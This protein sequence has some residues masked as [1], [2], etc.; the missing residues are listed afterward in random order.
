M[1]T[2]ATGSP[3]DA[4]N[5][6]PRQ[7]APRD[8]APAH[9]GF[10]GAAV[11]RIS[12]DCGAFCLRGW[13]EQGLTPARI[14]GLH[15]LL[16]HVFERGATQAA[17]PVASRNGDSLVRSGGRYWQLEPWMPGRS[18]FHRL[19]SRDR[20]RAAMQCL[21]CWH[22]AA[23]SFTARGGELAWFAQQPS[24]PSP[25]VVDRLEQIRQWSGDS[26]NLLRTRAEQDRS[27]LGR[28]GPAILDLHSRKAARVA[29]ELD[30]LLASRFELQPCLRDVWHDHVLFSGAEVTGLIDASAC[31]SESVAADLARL[32]G[33]L[34]RDDRAAWDFA[35]QAYAERR[36]LGPAEL[37]LVDA[38]D[39]SGVLL[40]GMTWLK[41]QYLDG[42]DIAARADVIDRLEAILAR[43]ERLE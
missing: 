11:V 16:A 34:V 23:R 17:V 15:R 18:D 30:G 4:L 7:Y 24:S 13:P 37:R 3:I 20:L 2:H 1:N 32:L 35:L 43:L 19:P 26:L 27:E 39:R 12:T 31:K 25:A 33:S 28:L 42:K 9:A 22:A 10:S 8:W 5:L 40:S 6:F 29:S 41:R 38:L 14:R 36:P 21:A